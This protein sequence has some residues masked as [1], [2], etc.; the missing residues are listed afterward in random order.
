MKFPQSPL[1]RG[2]MSSH[3]RLPA[4]FSAHGFPKAGHHLNGNVAFLFQLDSPPAH[5]A[6]ITS[7]WSDNWSELSVRN[8]LVVPRVPQVSITVGMKG[9]VQECT[10]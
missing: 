3:S 10:N 8:T 7:K 6:K 9:L 1:I 4:G 2:A 5:H